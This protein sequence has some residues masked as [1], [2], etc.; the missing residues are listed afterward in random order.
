MT[1]G[2]LL[3]AW[4]LLGSVFAHGPAIALEKVTLAQNQSPISGVSIIAKQLKFFEK[5]GLDVTVANFT[6]G[7]Q[8]LDTVI[9]GGAQI[10][11]TAEAPTTAAAMSR[12]P[13]AFL[14]RTEYSDLKTL[15]A[16]TAGIHTLADLKGKRIAY[17]AGT[18]GDVY[19]QAL[20]KK[21]GL[22]PADVKL[23]NLRPQ[24]MV[25]AMA[26]GSIDAFNTWEPH[27]TNGK[28]VLADGVTELDTRGIYAETFNIVVM[29]DYLATH[30]AVVDAFLRALIE[31]DEWMKA[32]REEGI[33]TVAG[34]VGMKRED[35]AAVWDNFRYEVVLDERT[36]DVLQQHAAWRLASGNAPTGAV[37]PDFRK[38]I[39][40]EPLKA[41]DPARVKVP[42]L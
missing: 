31:A 25:N 6:S 4:A 35:L 26:S 21:A 12:Q 5:H 18:G 9:G 14:A 16:K 33:T 32:H 40:A 37:M 11:T 17:T 10:A 2:R 7:K 19:T 13:I 3:L 20:L 34:F 23:L 36:V 29:Q 28:K 22:T 39:F 1:Y 8:C 38:V 41:L 27:I 15:T 24:D 30:R 42:G